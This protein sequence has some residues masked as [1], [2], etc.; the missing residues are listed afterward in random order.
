MV[1]LSVMCATENHQLL[2][3]AMGTHPTCTASGTIQPAV[4]PHPPLHHAWPSQVAPTSP[5]D[6]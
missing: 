5:S 1:T 3:P 4:S 2:Q 6:S